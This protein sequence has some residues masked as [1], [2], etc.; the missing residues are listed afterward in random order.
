VA[1]ATRSRSHTPCS[2]F[3]LGRS[4]TPLFPI[5]VVLPHPWILY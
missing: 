4:K 1:S 2:T 5:S 3:L